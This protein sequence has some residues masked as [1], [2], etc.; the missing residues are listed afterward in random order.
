MLENGC[1]E[2]PNRTLVDQGSAFAENFIAMCSLF[3]VSLSNIGIESHSGLGFGERYHQP[4]RSTFRK[5]STTYPQLSKELRLSV[6]V[7]EMNVT[8][9]PKCLVASDFVFRQFPQL[10]APAAGNLPRPDL[11]ERG[12]IENEARAEML[13]QMSKLCL[14]RALRHQVPSASEISYQPSDHVLVWRENAIG[15][16]IGEWMGPIITTSV[17]YCRR[18][19]VIDFGNET[20]LQFSFLS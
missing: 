6:A 5:I 13:N 4:L 15:R 19:A 9:G 10:R 8:L 16:R 3:I 1:T 11:V 18:L 7:K 14:N 20:V 2:I 17:D 12:K